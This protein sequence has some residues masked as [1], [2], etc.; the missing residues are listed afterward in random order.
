MKK[1]I[2]YRPIGETF[3]VNEVTLMVVV[4]LCGNCSGCFFCAAGGCACLRYRSP[5]AGA[6]SSGARGDRTSIIFKKVTTNGH[7]D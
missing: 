1:K 5:D 6:C 2:F 4:N 7:N 3:Q